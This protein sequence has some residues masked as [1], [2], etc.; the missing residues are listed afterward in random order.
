MSE[1]AAGAAGPYIGEAEI[2]RYQP[3]VGM[4][5]ITQQQLG[6]FADGDGPA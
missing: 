4:I 2:E 6:Y 3:V 1:D 5:C